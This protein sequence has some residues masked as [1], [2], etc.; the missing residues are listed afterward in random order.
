MKKR[1]A[2]SG[3]FLGTGWSF[4]PR[5]VAGDQPGSGRVEMRTAREDIEESLR[6]LCSTAPGERLFEPAFG[7]DLRAALF[8]ALDTTD[9][10]DLEDRARVAIAL[11]EPRIELLALEI[12]GADLAGRLSIEIEYRI[13]A[14]NSRFNLVLPFNELDANEL[15]FPRSFAATG[16]N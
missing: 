16:R 4:P 5:F 6:I 15:R 3:S 13:R 8:E 2:E 14:T 1:S 7:L 9:R 10:S 11:Y 12:T